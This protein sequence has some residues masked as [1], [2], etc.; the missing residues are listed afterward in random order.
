MRPTRLNPKKIQFISKSSVRAFDSVDQTF[1]W[2]WSFKSHFAKSK[3]KRI[4][5]LGLKSYQN[6]SV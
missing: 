3:T 6:K 2:V 4:Y 5:I 1:V